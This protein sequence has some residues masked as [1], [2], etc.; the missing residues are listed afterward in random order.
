MAISKSLLRN[1]QDFNSALADFLFPP[2]CCYCRE[3]L[4][5]VLREETSTGAEITTP[6]LCADCAAK[7]PTVTDN[8]CLKCGAPQGPHIP[9]EHGCVHC[10]RSH[11][12]FTEAISLHLYEDEF[13]KMCRFCKLDSGQNLTWYLARQLWQAEKNRLKSWQCNAVVHVPMYW[14][15]RLVRHVHPA[16]TIARCLA[17]CLGVPFWHRALNQ[18][19]QVPHQAGL[20]PS[21]RRKNVLGIYRAASFHNFRDKNILL[22]DDILTTGSTASECAKV[23]KAAG[24]KQVHV[25]VLARGAGR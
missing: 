11:F 12:A 25:A 6:R 5:S 9:S 18:V 3:S 10:K 21:V 1:C 24:A 4:S 22:I 13:R 23:L 15:R 7:L 16:E 2:N 8:H 19:R 20:S 17:S 14:T